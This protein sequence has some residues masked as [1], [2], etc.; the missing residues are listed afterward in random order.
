MRILG[1]ALG[2]GWAATIVWLSL[3]PRPPQI[4]VQFGDKIGH[5]GAYGLLML[6]FCILYPA[7]R[8]RIFHATGFI[9]MGVGLEFVQGWLGYRTFDVMDMA[10]NTIGV[11]LGWGSAVILR[12]LI[13]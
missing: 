1:L 7:L 12:K 3:T 11:L 5:F 13:V 6:G 8:A 10:A 2:W 9:A 4:D